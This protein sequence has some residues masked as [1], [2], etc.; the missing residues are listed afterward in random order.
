MAY[1]DNPEFGDEVLEK[2]RK[3][4]LENQARDIAN[5]KAKN[6]KKQQQEENE[7]NSNNNDI[8]DLKYQYKN[9]Y[10]RTKIFPLKTGQP[11]FF[12]KGFC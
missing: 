9:S 8:T 4:L 2:Y 1:R 12:L 5:G 11:N 3:E 6:N 7:N 10:K